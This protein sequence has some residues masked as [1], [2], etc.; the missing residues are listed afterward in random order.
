[1]AKQIPDPDLFVVHLTPQ[2]REEISR[3]LESVGSIENLGED[4][5]LLLRVK[6]TR[7]QVQPQPQAQWQRL[8]EMLG[9]SG[10]AQPVLTDE[11]G[12]PH[13][14]TGELT[15]RFLKRPSDKTLKKFAEKYGL[16]LRN[17]N[18]FVDEQAA[19][20]VTD[21]AAT[22]L[23]DLIQQITG[24]KTIKLA[25]ANTLSRQRRIK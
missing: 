15:V 9:S 2:N 23:P 4:N 21:P 24:D 20:Q 10:S 3:R 14:P 19:F 22:Y 17:R 12:H 16:R 1:M 5:T 18:E 7:S 8:T 6:K 11:T 13:Y 25:W